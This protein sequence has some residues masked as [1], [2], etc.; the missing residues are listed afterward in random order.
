VEP[1]EEE[2]HRWAQIG[3]AGEYKFNQ[4]AEQ[5]AKIKA[6]RAALLESDDPYEELIR[7]G[8]DQKRLDRAAAL[9]VL[10]YQR[11]AE[12]SDEQRALREE[13]TKRE[14]L[15]KQIKEHQEAQQAAERK[16]KSDA[17]HADKK[18]RYETALKLLESKGEGKVVLP[19]TS[20]FMTLMRMAHLE[21]SAFDHTPSAEELA[22]MVDA[23]LVAETALQV[24]GLKDD[25]QL[26]AWLERVGLEQNR[27]ARALRT[28]FNKR[29]LASQNGQPAPAA[30]PPA[31]KVER[32]LPQ[33]N[34]MN[35]QFVAT[36]TWPPP[37]APE[38]LRFLGHDPKK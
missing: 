13:R 4:L 36:P 27:V 11:A 7:Q 3:A 30:Q 21:D 6:L 2:F 10:K 28:A 14:A 33:R 35:G 24:S 23:D 17:F 22:G 25:D 26:V 5:E 38:F 19:E 37:P 9:R 12:E 16:Q 1:T 29:K 31:P 15:E 34:G 8:A 18:Q 32:Q 20:R